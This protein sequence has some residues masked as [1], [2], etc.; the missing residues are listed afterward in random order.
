MTRWIDAG[1]ARK[2]VAL[3]RAQGQPV[4]PVLSCAGL[5]AAALGRKGARIPFAAHVALLEHAAAA[6]RDPCFGLH[7]GA[8]L[9]PRDL[10]L[11]GYLGANAATLGDVLGVAAKY[12]RLLTEG[13]RVEVE[14][15]GERVRVAQ[16]LLDPAG[17]GSRQVAGLGAGSLVRVARLLTGTMLAPAWVELPFASGDDVA[18]H[19]RVLGAPI[20]LD[21][22]RTAVV[23]GRRQLEL[24]AVGADPDLFDILEQVC[25]ERVRALADPQDL[26]ARAETLIIELLPYGTPSID[27]VARR[28]GTSSRSLGRRL[29]EQR[30]S[31]KALVDDIRGELARLYLARGSHRPKAIAALLGY[32]DVSAFHHAFRRWTGTTPVRFRE[33]PRASC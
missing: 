24:R 20:R 18:E 1:L 16:H 8:A 12:L 29:A 7:L 10:G 3:L 14:A 30:T 27:R 9:H 11:V 28:L 23:L 17:A 32:K 26:R 21:Q 22:P 19:R 6:A 33:D 2:A 13:T 5:D 4:G 25:R 31:Y 15:A